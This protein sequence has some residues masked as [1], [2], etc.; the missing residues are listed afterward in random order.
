MYQLS[1]ADGGK[2]AQPIYVFK[3]VLC[4]EWWV[5]TAWLRLPWE[6]IVF[7]GEGKTSCAPW[8]RLVV[9]P[10]NRHTFI[11]MSGITKL[12]Y[13]MRP[14]ETNNE[15]AAVV[16]M[17]QFIYYKPFV[18]CSSNS[19][20]IFYLYSTIFV[21][22]V[23]LPVSFKTCCFLDNRFLLVNIKFYSQ[24]SVYQNAKCSLCIGC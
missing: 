23:C 24:W 19:S 6:K 21:L 10:D 7:Q 15:A 9:K 11:I 13:P 20:I 18:I 2:H 8:Q 3:R 14:S 1:G 16:L 4:L 22:L 17:H 12:F 5:T